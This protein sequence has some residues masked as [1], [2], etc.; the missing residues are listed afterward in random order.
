M[1]ELLALISWLTAFYLFALEW[2][3]ERDGKALSDLSKRYLEPAAREVRNETRDY[4][5]SLSDL[6]ERLFHPKRSKAN[7]ERIYDDL[8]RE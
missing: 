8:F 2:D 4:R 7:K 6:W 3:E 5:S 1:A